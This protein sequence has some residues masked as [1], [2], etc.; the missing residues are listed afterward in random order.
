[1]QEAV[2][3]SGIGAGVS[4]NSGSS[5]AG[6]G[7]RGGRGKGGPLTGAFYGDVIKPQMFGSSGGGGKTLGGGVLLINTSRLTLD[8]T[9]R[10][11]GQSA[12][13]KTLHGGASGGSIL[14][15]VETLE[16]SGSIE[17][18]GGAGG[19]AGG[20]GGSGGR[21]AIH[22]DQTLFTGTTTAYGGDS[23]TEAGAAGTIYNWDRQRNYRVLEVNNKGRKP[24][25]EDI[26]NYESLAEDSARTW[27]TLDSLSSVLTQV[28]VQDV[29]LTDEPKAVYNGYEFDEVHL[30]GSAH[31]AFEKDRERVRM[32]RL[33]KFSGDFQGGSYGF[34]HVGPLQFIVITETNY[35]IPMNLR[36]YRYGYIRL[37]PRLMLHK[38][39]L[40]LNGYLI[41][42]ND[43]T[44]SQCVVTF[45]E[46]SGAEVTGRLEY[47]HYTFKSLTIMDSGIVKGTNTVQQFTMNVDTLTVEAGGMLTGRYLSVMSR[48]LNVKESGQLNLDGQGMACEATN[49]YFAGSGGS[50]AGYGGLG[51]QQISRADPFDSVFQPKGFGRAGRA[52]RPAFPCD[53][54]RG[55]GA[56]QLTV[57]GIL[58]I[59]GTISS[60]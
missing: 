22:Y 4:E 11:N 29:E 7:G 46:R 25:T 18:D 15:H 59:D 12:A 34:L 44:V 16:G 35:Y 51:A 49:I 6:H 9:I 24:A 30:G 39:S 55:G 31:L 10:A 19:G 23:P 26:L 21:I 53:G 48:S 37:P 47:R 43:I 14:I 17:A 20:G 32:H 13:E 58:T 40:S 57:S 52:G 45:G 36:I 28:P 33:K 27:I 50:H 2:N 56:L 54:G 8:G 60:R 5:G 3:G 42:V 41:G 1:M 38:N